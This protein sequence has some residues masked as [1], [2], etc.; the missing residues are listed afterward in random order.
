MSS[1]RTKI[2]FGMFIVGGAAAIAACVGDSSPVNDGGPTDDATTDSTVK[3]DV[4]TDSPSSTDAPVDANDGGGIPTCDAAATFATP[5]ILNSLNLVPDAGGQDRG[6]HL[7]PDYLVAYFQY[8]NTIYTA[9]RTSPSGDTF[10]P[11]QEL[12]QV[13][14]VPDAATQ[15]TSPTPSSDGLTLYFASDRSGILQIYVSTRGSITSTFGAP[16]LV[17]GL[18]TNVALSAP[19]LQGDGSTLYFLEAG[20]LI[21]RAPITNGLVGVPVAVA[22]LNAGG[23]G[24]IAV[25]ADGLTAY[26]SRAELPD[27][28]VGGHQKVWTAS[29]TSTSAQF[30]NIQPVIAL[31]GP[32]GVNDD[33]T[34]VSNDG[35]QVILSSFRDPGSNLYVG[36]KP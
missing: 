22:E 2:G 6:G 26:F 36:I 3:P 23:G 31:N 18:P 9:T 17:A 20:N 1:S 5:Y 32:D 35:C 28:S 27:G 16:S 8:A 19:F 14:L 34:W 25:T 12:T 21:Y 33:I 15:S 29:R 10:S 11:P 30:G 4:S 24:P 7:T 13:D